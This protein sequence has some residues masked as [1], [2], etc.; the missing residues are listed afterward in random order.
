MG[1]YTELIREKDARNQKCQ[2]AA[3]RL[4]LEDAPLTMDAL[5][6]VQ[7]A[8]EF[9]L[10]AFGL[11]CPRVQDCGSARELIESVLDG[12]GLMSEEVD[13]SDRSFLRRTDWILAW[14]QDG[15]AVVLKP[16]LL[17]YTCIDAEFR[18]G[19]RLNRH[20]QLKKHGYIIHRCVSDDK[21]SARGIARLIL[22]LVSARDLL[23]VLACTALISLLGMA[24]PALNSWALNSLLPMGGRAYGALV[25]GAA[26]FITVGVFRAVLSALMTN[27]L[28]SMRIR[29][30]D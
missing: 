15:R 4:L 26:I 9:I 11:E 17:G 21:G 2:D 13:L 23:A 12:A 18:H 19:K 24:L 22:Q 30:A 28:S 25:Y 8:L 1:L 29:I 6:G 3:D 7:A 5:S 27:L 10:S 16:S 14:T 20:V